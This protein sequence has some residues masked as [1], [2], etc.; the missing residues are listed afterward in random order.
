M[1]SRKTGFAAGGIGEPDCARNGA[2]MIA[3][4]TANRKHRV[5]TS[6]KNFLRPHN[7]SIAIKKPHEKPWGF[8]AALLLA[9]SAVLCGSGG[10]PGLR[11]FSR[12]QWR[13][14]GRFARP[15]PLPMP[16]N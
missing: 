9:K 13:D 5:A 11:L 14:R 12:S 6:F 7:S 4:E 1:T 2:A 16:A 8:A 3:T 10:W 15:S